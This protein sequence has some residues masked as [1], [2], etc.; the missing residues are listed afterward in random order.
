MLYVLPLNELFACADSADSDEAE[1]RQILAKS[2]IKPFVLNHD[3]LIPF[4][5]LCIVLCIVSHR[6]CC[7]VSRAAS[8]KL[9]S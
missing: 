4:A 2:V 8:T 7:M 1:I 9:I 5:V 3:W 6:G